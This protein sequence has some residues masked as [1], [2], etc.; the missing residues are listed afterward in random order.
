MTRD[1]SPL[2]PG[3]LAGAYPNPVHRDLEAVRAAYAVRESG[4]ERRIAALEAEASALKERLR[5]TDT[6]L[7]SLRERYTALFLGDFGG[8]NIWDNWP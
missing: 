1:R 4:L 2:P 7:S 6:Q 3:D 8:V 5:D